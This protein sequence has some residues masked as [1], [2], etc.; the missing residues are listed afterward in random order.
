[1]RVINENDNDNENV[2]SFKFQ[3]ESGEWRVESQ[4]RVESLLFTVY[5]LQESLRE[6]LYKNLNQNFYEEIFFW[7]K[8]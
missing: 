4:L 6:K 7:T 3:V 5:C 8:S 1:M 2:S